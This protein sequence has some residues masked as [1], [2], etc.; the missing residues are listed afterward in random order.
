M[1]E[2]ICIPDSLDGVERMLEE[3]HW[4]R[5]TYNRL[6]Y[7]RRVLMHKRFGSLTVRQQLFGFRR[8]RITREQENE[9]RLRSEIKNLLDEARRYGYNI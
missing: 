6:A 5:C 1:R 8:G 3:G 7:K 2:Q 4:D 9:I